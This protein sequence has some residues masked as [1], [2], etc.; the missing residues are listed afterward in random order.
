MTINAPLSELRVASALRTYERIKL[1][2][3]VAVLVINMGIG[4]YLTSIART[5]KRTLDN[6]HQSLVILRCAL[7]RKTA[8]KPSGA[9]RTPEEYRTELA[10]CIR[11]TP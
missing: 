7:D 4:L 1:G 2:L 8:V 10:R 3:L 5:N 9:P 6:G 11:E